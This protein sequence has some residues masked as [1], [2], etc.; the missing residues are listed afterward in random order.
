MLYVKSWRNFI[1]KLYKPLSE[2]MGIYI[3]FMAHCARMRKFRLIFNIN[4]L[5]LKSLCMFILSTSLTTP[6]PCMLVDMYIYTYIYIYIYMCV[7]VCVKEQ[8]QYIK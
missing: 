4:T 7:C 8:V 6:S 5:K 3:N 2:F 1:E